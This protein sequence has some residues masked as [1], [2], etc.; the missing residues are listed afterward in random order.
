GNIKRVHYLRSPL[1]TP[2]KRLRPEK[3]SRNTPHTTRKSDPNSFDCT[4]PCS[5]QAGD[6]VVIHW[7]QEEPT[8]APAHSYYYKKDQLELQHQRFRGR[9]A[10]FLDQLSRGSASLKLTKVVF[11]D[12]GR[13]KCYTNSCSGSNLVKKKHKKIT[14][15]LFP[16]ENL[17]A[18]PVREVHMQQEGD[19]IT[20]SSGGI[21]PEP[22]LTWT[23]S[24]PSGAILKSTTIV[25]LSQQQ[26]YNISSS[27]TLSHSDAD[28][29][30]NCTV[31]TA[32]GEKTATLTSP[33]KARQQ[34]YRSGEW[35]LY[36][37]HIILL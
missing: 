27:L 1:P 35:N 8:K 5:F 28:L 25:Q 6:E 11:E 15:S 3:I 13:Y 17:D 9:T 31:S 32:S 26:L 29:A 23:A 4:L 34:Q 21:Y 30:Y 10:L 22:N 24:P 19:R 2:P 7:I 16:N 14:F 37:Q 36:K 33:V 18:A 12:A 20:C